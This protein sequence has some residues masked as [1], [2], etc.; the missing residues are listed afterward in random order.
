MAESFIFSVA[1]SLTAKFASCAYQEASRVVGVYDD[2][3]DLKASLSYVKAVLL[4]AEQKQ[5]QIKLMSSGSGSSRSN[6]SSMMLRT[7]SMKLT[8]KLCA[9]K[10]SETMVLL[11]TR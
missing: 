4:D 8:A 6:S 2:L 10:S 1:E 5:E 11:K 9:S 7:C 3:Q